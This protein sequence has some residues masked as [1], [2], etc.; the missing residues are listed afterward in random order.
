[1]GRNLVLDPEA[2]RQSAGR[3]AGYEVRGGSQMRTSED[4]LEATG[5][6]WSPRRPLT[7]FAPPMR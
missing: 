2:A 5:T 7:A 4:E 1:M 6:K 3:M